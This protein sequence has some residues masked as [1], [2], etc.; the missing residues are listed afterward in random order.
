M[1]FYAF[2]DEVVYYCYDKDDVLLYIGRTTRLKKRMG[3]HSRESGWWPNVDRLE[4]EGPLSGPIAHVAEW[5]QIGRL[6][7]LH[8]KVGNRRRGWGYSPS[9]RTIGYSAD[10]DEFKVA[11]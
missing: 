6:A 3:Q 9:R 1:T 4:F 10:R 11:A 8:N 7:P 5:M 2:A